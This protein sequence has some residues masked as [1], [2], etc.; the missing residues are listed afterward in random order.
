M[1]MSR[2]NMYASPPCYK[3]NIYTDQHCPVCG[4]PLR[5]DANRNGCFCTEHP[6]ERATGEFHVRF[7]KV[8][9]RFKDFWLAHQ[10]L[11]GLRHEQSMG[12]HDP[13]RY[14]HSQP[15]KFTK[16]S[17][18]WLDG[19]RCSDS[20]K[21]NLRRYIITAQEA[22]GN[23]LVDSIS[24]GDIEDFLN[25]LD[26]SDKTRS[27]YASALHALFA[28]VE[29]RENI[30]APEIPKID[31]TLGWREIVDIPTQ[32]AIIGKVHE[33][34]PYR[35]WLGIKWLST[36]I[37]IRPKELWQLRER[38]IDVSGFFVL[39]PETVKTKEPKLVPILQEDIELY[40]ALP[41]GLPD[42]PF[43]RWDADHPRTPGKQFGPN[44]FY[45][46]WKRACAELGIEGVDLY[47][48]TRH[49]TTTAISKHFSKEELRD[50]GTMHGTNK[51][52]ERYM[53][54]DVTPSKAIYAKVRQLIERRGKVI[55]FPS[56]DDDDK[57]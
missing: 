13:R 29:R 36:Y 53:Q 14:A 51:A 27:N 18:K 42:L 40:H 47:G 37:S 17:R 31:Y 39:R 33:I 38:D 25:G 3:G 22:W 54:G 19:K 20:H 26:V 48:G 1:R 50:H 46:W 45:Q 4:S 55:P 23:R 15:L 34:A 24:Y 52:F 16:L 44:L 57:K 5:H 21:R 8:R 49:S 11:N 35:V 32:T 10:F 56:P 30:Q 7:G 28:W 6:E 2:T 9:K 43:F 12:T 41:T